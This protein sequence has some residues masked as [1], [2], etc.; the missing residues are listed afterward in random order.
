MARG[1]TAEEIGLLGNLQPLKDFGDLLALDLQGEIVDAVATPSGDGY[2][3]LGSDG[4]VFAFGDA[5][6]WGSIQQYLNDNAFGILA[7]DWLDAPI[8]GI[9]PTP[10]GLGYWLVASDGG[11][12]AFGDAWFVG[13]IPGVL[14]PGTQLAAPIN[15]MVTYG[16]GYVMVADDGGVFNFSDLPFDGS[17]GD[18]PPDSPVVGIA[19]LPT[20]P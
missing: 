3:M 17:L 20:S 15:S 13:S 7:T 1:T 6:F 14:P 5:K 19:P 10:S 16:N 12:F 8:V 18:N 9:V 11:V 4:G 2:Y